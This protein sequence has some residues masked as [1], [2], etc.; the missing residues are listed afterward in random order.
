MAR[1]K[2]TRPKIAALWALEKTVGT[3]AFG[4][5]PAIDVVPPEMG[6]RL[7]PAGEATIAE[8][9]SGRFDAGLAPIAP[10]SFKDD[11][12]AL[13][14]E[15]DVPEASVKLLNADHFHFD[16]FAD[17]L[18]P[19][20]AKQVRISGVIE[21]ELTSNPI[22]GEMEQVTAVSGNPL[23]AQAAKESAEKWHLVPGT[24]NALHATRAVL[25]FVFHCP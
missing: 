10:R 23:L 2:R 15:S 7:E 8:L 16:R 22:T 17:P 9:K 3:R 14:P 4:A 24:D 5:F 20:L 6:A 21:L 25:E 12:T 13:R 19:A 1:L 18:Y 11:L